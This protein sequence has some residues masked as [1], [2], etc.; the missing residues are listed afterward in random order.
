MSNYNNNI[1]EV[2]NYNRGDDMPHH[3]D[4]IF[5]EMISDL[6]MIKIATVLSFKKR[7]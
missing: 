6:T 7:K 1:L 4:S 3:I 2:L 5:N